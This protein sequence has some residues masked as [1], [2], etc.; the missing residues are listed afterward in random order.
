VLAPE[1]PEFHEHRCE[2]AILTNLAHRNGLK[3]YRTACQAGASQP[4]DQH[5]YGQL[6]FQE[7]SQ[8]DRLDYSGSRFR[9]VK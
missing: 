3:L 6:F 2:Q 1:H 5:L 9:N 8:G 7:D 4:E